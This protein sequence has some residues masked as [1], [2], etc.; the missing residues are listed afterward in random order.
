[1]S[2]GTEGRPIFLTGMM[3]SG[4]STVGRLLAERLGYGF[5]DLDQRVEHLFGSRIGELFEQGEAH[6]RECERHALRSLLAEPGVSSRGLVVA[7]GGGVV[8]AGENLAAM[9]SAGVI[10]FLDVPPASLSAR[11][12]AAQRGSRPLLESVPG[13]T[14]EQRLDELLRSRR[15]SYEAC[16]IMIDADDE[17]S[18]VVERLT[19]ALEVA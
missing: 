15:T 5:I 17:A 2:F 3:G 18:V 11:L 1:M 19:Q 13:A 10:A 12:D 8:L 7:T 14:L 6:F 4:K 9:R 16:D